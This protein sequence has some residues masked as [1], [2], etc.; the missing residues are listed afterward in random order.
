[1]KTL[2][3][4]LTLIIL[5]SLTAVTGTWATPNGTTDDAPSTLFEYMD[6]PEILKVTLEMDIETL[7]DN[8]RTNDFLPAS[9]SFQN[10]QGQLSNWDIEVRVRGRF[11]R[12]SCEFPPLKLKFPKAEMKAEG[13]GKHNDVKL[14]TH[15]ADSKEGEENLFREYLTYKM[16]AQLTDVS[17]RVQ[18]IDIT[19]I[20]SNTGAETSTY[21]IL[22]EDADEM[23]ERLNAKECEDCFGMTAAQMDRSNVQIHDLFQYMIGNTDW[24]VKMVRNMKILKPAN[25]E[26]AKLVAP[27]DFDFSGLVNAAYAKP[28]VDLQQKDIRDRIYIGSNWTAEE[29]QETIDLFQS[30]RQSFM[31]MVDNFEKISNKAK[32][33]IKKYLNGFYEEL[34]GGFVPQNVTH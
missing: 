13:F 3:N 4:H 22:I 23:A 7:L 29:W 26:G 21:G 14:V 33:D 31:S 5:V 10:S 6:Q 18:L 25:E 28:N 30:K 17:F 19:Y 2:I 12:M 9:F 32:K 27:Y 15:C 20:D 34:D 11:R 8:K 24:S 1:M 16:Y